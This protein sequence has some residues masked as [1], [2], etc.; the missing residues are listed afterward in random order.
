V[1]HPSNWLLVIACG[2]ACASPDLMWMPDWIRL[3]SGKKPKM[4]GIFK[5]FH[6]KVQWAE[7][8]AWW[9]FATEVVCS[10]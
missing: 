5:K 7:K 10:V 8:Y 1:L 4:P 9:G 6:A 3:I 2:V